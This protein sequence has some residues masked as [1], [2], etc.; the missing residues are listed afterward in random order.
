MTQVRCD[1]LTS[2]TGSTD[3]WANLLQGALSAVVGGLVAA[4]TAWAVV[5]G[6]NRHE[7]RHTAQQNAVS[8]AQAALA[9]IDILFTSVLAI[10][11]WKHRI[12]DGE[13]KR[14]LNAANSRFL[15]RTRGH[16]AVIRSIDMAFADRMDDLRM[17]I[18]K[19]APHDEDDHVRW[20]GQDAGRFFEAGQRFIHEIS[21][22]LESH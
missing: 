15:I 7:R 11:P 20:R 21:Q 18:I 2:M 4:L 5:M 13:W 8:A 22:W 10:R 14:E 17:A 16:R 19:A 6:T 9:E 1:R 3:W 12:I